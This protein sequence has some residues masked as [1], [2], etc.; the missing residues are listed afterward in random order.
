MPSWGRFLVFVA[1]IGGLSALVHYY[2]WSRLIREAVL[3]PSWAR[4][5]TILIITMGI[6]MPLSMPVARLLPRSVALPI[7]V[8]IYTWMGILLFLFLGSV[9]G[10][11]VRL[12]VVV[13]DR[14]RGADVD[15]Q[16]RALLGRG[17]AIVTAIAAA[18]IAG[19]GLVSAR[20]PIAIKKVKVK[21]ARLPASM[22]GLTI[23]QITDVHIG[24]TIGRGF[25]ESVVERVNALAADVIVITGDLVDGTV[26]ELREHA[27]PLAQLRAKHGVF[28]VTGNHEYYSGVDE[29][30]TELRRLG[31]RPLRNERVTI[32]HEGGALDLAGIDDFSAHGGGH[33]PDLA[34]ALAGR[35]PTRELVLLAHQPR[36]IKEAAEHGV[37]LQLSGHT[38]GGQLWPW[39]YLV[40]LQQPYVAGLHRHGDAQI[41]VS[42]G[43]GY[44]GPPMRVGA[45]AE[46]THL[47]LE[48]A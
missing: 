19:Y 44:W 39:T 10:D 38:H 9:I 25:I 31:I 33:G 45:P 28:F 47:T 21:L 41:Y 43:T 26:E 42:R 23:A 35:D 32:E 40:F 8:V 27:A 37:G 11:L 2:V 5:G 15:P 16:R 3:P 7:A 46:I 14:V 18:S 24:P 22:N 30:L 12:G 34:R 36:A 13:V 1:V 6:A 20:G 4:L 17:I 48:Q 29:W